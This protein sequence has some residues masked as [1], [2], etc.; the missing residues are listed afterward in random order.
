MTREL[1]D[2]TLE[3]GVATL[4]LNNPPVNV[5]TLRLTQELGEC[6]AELA[7]DPRV[8]VVVLTGAG[9]KAFCAGSDIKEFVQLMDLAV[10]VDK[11]MIK[12]NL[13]Y[14]A[15]DN[16]PKRP[17]PPSTVWLW[18]EAQSWRSAAISG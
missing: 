12:D 4:V 9:S 10:V 7:A 5:V 6:L 15:L 3:G 17:S 1:V 8:R 14:D 13:V 18:A 11:K 16:L 2:W